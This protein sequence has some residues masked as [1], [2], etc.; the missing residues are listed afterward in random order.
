MLASKRAR[1][2][3]SVLVSGALAL[4]AGC[5]DDSDGDDGQA[6]AGGDVGGAGGAVG[7]TGGDVGGAGGEAGGAGGEAIPPL[8]QPDDLAMA[9]ALWDEIE[10]HQMTWR[11]PAAK[12]GWVTGAAPHGGVQQFYQNGTDPNAEGYIV[13]KRNYGDEDEGALG[14]LTV[15]QKVPGFDSEVGDW[16]YAKYLPDGTLD[17]NADGLALAGRP[18]KGTASGCVGCH[19]GAPG[20]DFLFSFDGDEIPSGPPMGRPWDLEM[21]ANLWAEIEDH[22]SWDA[23]EGK[24]GWQQGSMPHGA[25]QRFYHN[26]ADN[27]ADGYIIIKKNYGA[28]DEASLGAYTVMKKIEGFDDEVGD[29]FY[30]KYLPDGTLDVNADGVPLVGRPG[31]GTAGGCVGCHSGAP[32]GDFLFS[33]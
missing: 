23:P 20:D 27:T 28:E 16:F 17:V 2:W 9:E 5:D 12:G 15:M 10:Q 3:T 13:I 19:T 30:A 32:G 29:W 1:I 25:S 7:G 26:G 31:K 21:A 11:Q 24:A 6:G 14:A 33:F 8:G 18:G 22:A 4:T